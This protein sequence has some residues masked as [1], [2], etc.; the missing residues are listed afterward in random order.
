M[1]S[2]L[3]KCVPTKAGWNSTYFMLFAFLENV[4]AAL[5]HS[6][7][8][9]VFFFFFLSRSRPCFKST[10]IT[11]VQAVPSIGIDLRSLL[12][13]RLQCAEPC[14]HWL[15]LTFSEYV[16]HLL[17]DCVGCS[18]ANLA[19]R[20]H[21]KHEPLQQLPLTWPFLLSWTNI[22]ISNREK[23]L[24]TTKEEMQRALGTQTRTQ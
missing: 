13:A 16:S 2:W 1:C 4:H 10:K 17:I 7:C 14:F 8:V 5:S 23:D 18:F 9:C 3:N 20:N 12:E 6:V 19:T 22:V 21:W 11:G 24:Y 15:S